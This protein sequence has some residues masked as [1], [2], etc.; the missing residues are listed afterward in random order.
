MAGKEQTKALATQQYVRGVRLLEAPRRFEG[1]VNLVVG[2]EEK[3]EEQHK[4]LVRRVPQIF[5]PEYLLGDLGPPIDRTRLSEPKS[6][7]LA[8]VDRAG[9]YATVPNQ[10]G[11]R[12]FL[13]TVGMAHLEGARFESPVDVWN[14]FRHNIALDVRSKLVEGG[15]L[16][17]RKFVRYDPKWEVAAIQQLDLVDRVLQLFGVPL[18]RIAR[19][20]LYGFIDLF[21][22]RC[23][24][25]IGLAEI[26]GEVER[27]RA[28]QATYENLTAALH[29]PKPLRPV[30]VPREGNLRWS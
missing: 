20:E 23:K 8:I 3:K 21:G 30:T 19:R 16:L 6:Y 17:A 28:L 18:E 27:A 13:N 12:N 11:V 2:Q 4:G 10:E 25:T 22:E 1:L 29:D 5:T 15:I 26:N 14:G 24:A 9:K 7:L